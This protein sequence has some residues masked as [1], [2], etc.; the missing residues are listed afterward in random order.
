MLPLAW[1]HK[2]RP[3]NG[4][5]TWGG[6]VTVAAMTSKSVVANYGQFLAFYFL[7]NY[8]NTGLPII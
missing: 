3:A 5:L 1:R 8:E 6:G 7:L 2:R 4:T